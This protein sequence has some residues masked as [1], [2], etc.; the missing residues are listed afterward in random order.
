MD[1]L[2][3]P[4]ILELEYSFCTV[5]QVLEQ[6]ATATK[7]T[8]RTKH[9]P[10]VKKE[11]KPLEARKTRP[12]KQTKYFCKKCNVDVCNACFR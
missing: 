6:R 7:P 1:M 2:H 8:V 10:V 9:E 4:C 11:R 5:S 12:P 3:L